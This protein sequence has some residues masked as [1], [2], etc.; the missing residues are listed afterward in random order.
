MPTASSAAAAA[1]LA[2][3]GCWLGPH[4]PVL[5]AP[6]ARTALWQ[7]YTAAPGRN[8]TCCSPGAGTRRWQTSYPCTRSLAGRHTLAARRRTPAPGARSA[9]GGQL[10]GCHGLPQPA[11]GAPMGAPCQ[12]QNPQLQLPQLTPQSTMHQVSR[13]RP[14]KRGSCTVATWWPGC[15]RNAS[16]TPASTPARTLRRVNDPA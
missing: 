8:H 7:S 14:A 3:H 15:R 10:E 16:A 13:L 11:S 2:T 6:P 9:A 12:A 1:Q 5:R 4:R